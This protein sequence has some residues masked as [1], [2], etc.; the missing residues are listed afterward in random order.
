MSMKNKF[1]DLHCHSKFSDGDKN[2]EQL[3]ELF[4]HTN[5]KFAAITDH[6]DLKSIKK[7]LKL[8]VEDIVFIPGVE[9]STVYYDKTGKDYYIHILGYGI[10]HNY[11]PL[12]QE[13][14]RFRQNR[15]ENNLQLLAK[16]EKSGTIIPQCIYEQVR[17]E[18]Y[19]SIISE[20]KKCLK[21]N[22][23]NNE[24][25]SSFTQTAKTFLPEYEDYE[26]NVFKAINLIREAGGVPVLAHPQ[27]IK[28]T[29]EQLFYFIKKAKNK[30][31]MG[32]EVFYSEFDESI[33]FYNESLAEYF[34]L[35]KSVGSDFHI[36]DEDNKL[37]GLGINY[38]LCK[39]ECSLLNYLLEHKL[40]LN[41]NLI[42]T[43]E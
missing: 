10:D 26:M 21:K 30:G 29:E 39:T 5:T 23:F 14:L 22:N 18:N 11:E 12:K 17:L 28:F 24:F 25:I 13:M 35:L 9:L 31:L 33:I 6:D 27:K 37:P 2:I 38:N 4:R 3:I 36:I 19:N 34:G 40:V 41:P 43:Q 16:I 15:Y 42:T 32:I 1:I 7:L 8:N 20:F